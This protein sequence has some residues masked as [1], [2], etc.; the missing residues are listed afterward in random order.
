MPVWVVSMDRPTGVSNE[1][2]IVVIKTRSPAVSFDS[3]LFHFMRGECDCECQLEFRAF[4]QLFLKFR[5][6]GLD[7]ALLYCG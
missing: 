4:K 5:W 6:T 2:V 7:R 1:N 3:K